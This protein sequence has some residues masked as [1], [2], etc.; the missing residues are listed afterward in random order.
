MPKKT[1]TARWGPATTYSHPADPDLKNPLDPRTEPTIPEASFAFN[2]R[3]GPDK[4]REYRCTYRAARVS[5]RFG[6]ICR[7][8]CPL[9]GGRSDA[10]SACGVRPRYLLRRGFSTTP[11]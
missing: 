9:R 4:C 2:T 5:K 7:D 1:E 11:G 8:R 10:R 6:E 3:A